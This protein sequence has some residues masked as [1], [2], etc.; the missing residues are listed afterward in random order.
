M[1]PPA[2]T[3]V[4]RALRAEVFRECPRKLGVFEGV[5]HGVSPG[6][7]GSKVPFSHSGDTLGTFFDSL[8]HPQFSGTLS[9]RARKTPVAG[10]GVHNL[11]VN[12]INF[13]Q[14]HLAGNVGNFEDVFEHCL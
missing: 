13:W 10:R 2:A 8:E 4:F 3:R 9:G 14:E 5:S 6:A 7:P 12:C 1:N 11:S